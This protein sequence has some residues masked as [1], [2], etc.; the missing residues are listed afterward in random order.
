MYSF[1][2]NDTEV[3]FG[4]WLKQVSDLSSEV[5]ESPMFK[6]LDEL[7]SSNTSISV[8]EQVKQQFKEFLKH[9]STTVFEINDPNQ[10][11]DFKNIRAALKQ[12][13][14]IV[15]MSEPGQFIDRLNHFRNESGKDML[16]VVDPDQAESLKTHIAGVI[17]KLNTLIQ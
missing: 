1:N 8:S 11:Q 3:T 6:L 14:A 12:I 5:Q 13:A 2:A 4:E 17:D 15:E 7:T 9:P 16:P 10:L